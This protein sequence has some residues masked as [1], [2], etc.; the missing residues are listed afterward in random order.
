MYDKIYEILRSSIHPEVWEHVKHLK[1][2]CE[3]WKEL[4]E[5]CS[6]YEHR[7]LNDEFWY[8]PLGRSRRFAAQGERSYKKYPQKGE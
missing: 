2:P 7:K 3:I 8:I 5:V 4:E 1:S 6:K